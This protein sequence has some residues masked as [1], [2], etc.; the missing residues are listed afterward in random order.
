[1]LIASVCASRFVPYR[2]VNK[3][4]LDTRAFPFPPE[5]AQAPIA[6]SGFEVIAP[7]PPPA[8]FA[9][10]GHTATPAR[11]HWSWVMLHP[12]A[13]A[14]FCHGSKAMIPLDIPQP[15]AARLEAPSCQAFPVHMTTRPCG[16]H[17]SVES[18]SSID[19]PNFLGRYPASAIISC[20][21]VPCRHLLPRFWFGR[22][23]ARGTITARRGMYSR[24]RARA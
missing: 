9:S 8:A 12:N 16:L 23:G 6:I 2:V 24:S 21:I 10:N 17:A 15:I 19:P 13:L 3:T 20:R 7:V 11:L 1:M 5:M 18:H 14:L 4:V 22:N